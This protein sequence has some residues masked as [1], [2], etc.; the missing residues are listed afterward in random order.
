MLKEE[1]IT[2]TIART[3]VDRSEEDE[4]GA[5]DEEEGERLVELACLVQLLMPVDM[6]DWRKK[7]M[8]GTEDRVVV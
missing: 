6:A 3:V 7:L 1:I 8:G 2:H 5:K 4:S